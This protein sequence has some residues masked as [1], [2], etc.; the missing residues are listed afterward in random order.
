[1]RLVLS[2]LLVLACAGIPVRAA[3]A[4]AAPGA[5][6]ACVV[7]RA[8]PAN[9]PPAWLLLAV[10]LVLVGAGRLATS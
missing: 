6:P 8:S 5:V 9:E 7:A 1:M 10:A 2:C 3:P 4:A